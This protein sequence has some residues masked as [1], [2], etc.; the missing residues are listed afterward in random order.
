M[1]KQQRL[2]LSEGGFAVLEI[3]IIIVILVLLGLPGFLIYQ[4]YNNGLLS[5]FDKNS[6]KEACSLTDGMRFC[7][8]VS[9]TSVSPSDKLTI[10]A[11]L[12]NQTSKTVQI[13]SISCDELTAIINNKEK[14]SN[15][16]CPGDISTD[17]INPGDMRTSEIN[18]DTAKLKTGSNRIVIKWN[19]EKFVSKPIEIE[20]KPETEAD[21]AKFDTCLGEQ[22]EHTYCSMVS[23]IFKKGTYKEETATCDDFDSYIKPLGLKALREYCT[24]ANTGI[25]AVYVPKNNLDNWVKK[26]KQ[27]PTVESVNTDN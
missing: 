9:S 23:I 17:D 2:K 13:H 6:N 25:I 26:I 11:T 8:K 20:L 19:A 22:T 7:I 18:V 3:I 5:I 27:L 24:L 1:I 4:N 21:Q 10:Q 16:E 12:I 15:S 14:M